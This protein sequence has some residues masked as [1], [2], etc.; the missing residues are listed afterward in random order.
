VDIK[1]KTGEVLE[2]KLEGVIKKKEVT[3]SGEER[4]Q[5]ER[6]KNGF[7]ERYGETEAFSE[8]KRLEGQE[9]NKRN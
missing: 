3:A 5:V 6:E 4:G 9:R 8:D 2:T 7:A 1:P